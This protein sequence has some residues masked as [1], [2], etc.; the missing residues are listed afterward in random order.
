MT[1]SRVSEII[2]I[3]VPVYPSSLNKFPSW[4]VCADIAHA[5]CLRFFGRDILVCVIN[6]LKRACLIK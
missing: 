3:K 6:P 5:V 1:C 2:L 4:R